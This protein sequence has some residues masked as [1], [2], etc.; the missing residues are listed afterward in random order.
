[1]LAECDLSA[2]WRE[3]TGMHRE[4]LEQKGISLTADIDRAQ[5]KAHVDANQIRQVFLNLFRN[6]VD[7]TATG[8]SITIGLLLED[9]N[10]I[11]SISDT[12]TGIPE[13]RLA[14]VFDL[15][16]TTKSKGTGL[17]LAICRKIVEDHGGQIV[18]ASREQDV[19][20]GPRGTTVTVKIPFRVGVQVPPA[21]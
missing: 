14:K 1:M 4:E 15:F 20:E 7:A 2:L 13:H 5:T 21:L 9:R 3:V 12:G 8:G 19:R 11:F 18:L 16:Y 10:I 17:G 6:A